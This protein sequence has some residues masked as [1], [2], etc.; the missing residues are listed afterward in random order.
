MFYPFLNTKIKNKIVFDK[1]PYSIVRSLS[2]SITD[3]FNLPE[4][5][6]PLIY[7]VK[8]V[9]P[10]KMFDGELDAT[11]N[12]GKIKIRPNLPILGAPIIKCEGNDIKFIGI[13][14]NYKDGCAE[15]NPKLLRKILDY[16]FDL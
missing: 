16:F 1:P 9:T 3:Y 14:E 11:Q 4:E 7:K 6:K 5:P 8:I 13:V 15:T 10:Y 12:P 2:D